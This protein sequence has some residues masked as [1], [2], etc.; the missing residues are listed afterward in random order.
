VKIQQQREKEMKTK[1]NDTPLDTVPVNNLTTE[2]I[3]RGVTTPAEM[4]RVPVAE[5]MQIV[6]LIIESLKADNMAVTMDAMAI[7]EKFVWPTDYHNID[8]EA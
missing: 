4:Q 5:R 2:L 8:T 7:R 6:E 3:H 1:G